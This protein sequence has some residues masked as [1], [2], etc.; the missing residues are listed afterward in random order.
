[1][2]ARINKIR[3]ID[4]IEPDVVWDYIKQVSESSTKEILL[5]SLLPTSKDERVSCLSFYSYQALKTRE[6]I[7]VVKGLGKMVKDCYVIALP[8][9]KDIHPV[10]LPL[11]EPG[12]SIKEILG[13]YAERN[14]MLLALIFK[15]KAEDETR[16]KNE[17]KKKAA[18]DLSDVEEPPPPP[19][20]DE[21][22]EV[23]A[24][25]A[26]AKKAVSDICD[27]FGLNDVDLDYTKADY[28]NLT[29]YKL[30]QQTYQSRIQGANPKSPK[31]KLM[32][33][34]AAKWREFQAWAAFMNDNFGPS[35]KRA[36]KL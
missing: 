30:F 19:E 31:P 34:L 29:T 4:F 23:V 22:E 14:D 21:V 11:M 32:M 20:E 25:K 24:P 6:R 2:V 10:L 27:N 13:L 33:L 35:K 1:M 9:E 17:A 18:S 26:K 12:W 3:I 5:I 15:K 36:K 28:Q 16:L 8:K 7:G